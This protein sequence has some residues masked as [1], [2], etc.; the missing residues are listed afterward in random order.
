MATVITE[1]CINC[2][3]C[4]PECPN[5]AIYQGGVEY[6]W[7]GKKNP[8]IADE[9]FYIVPEKCTECVGFFDH[10]ACAA[11][12]PV[13]C[14][15][16][17]PARPE[18]EAALLQRAR[19]LHPDKEFAD[20]APSRFR[21]GSGDGAAAKAPAAPAAQLQAAAAPAAAVAATAVAA[22]PAP[23]AGGRVEKAIVRPT[24][25]L[26]AG[27]PNRELTGEL[28]GSFEDALAKVRRPKH[29]GGSLA[30]GLGLLAA[31]PILGALDH[32]TKLGIEQ[33]YGDP[34]FFSS[35]LS[36]AINVI[37]NFFLYPILLFVA[38]VLGG[39]QMFTEA[40]KTPIVM[41]VLIASIE[42]AV[43]LRDGVFHAKP[44]SEIRYGASI[45]GLPLGLVLR[46]I[47]SRF[48]KARRSGWVP[49]EGFYAR[50]FE[51]KRE[52]EKR[53]GEV[54]TVDEF[55]HGYYVRMEL[56][57]EIPPSA[58]RDELGIGKEMP[59][60][61]LRVAL[62]DGSLSIRG[63]VVDPD[64]RAICGVSPAFPA[65]FKTAIPLDAAIAGFRRRY[66]D[67]L[68]EVVVLKQGA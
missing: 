19:E 35:Q 12:C 10:E 23:A 5:T 31:S 26:K 1:E 13:D 58:A 20:D 6:D 9:I 50:E 32:K 11:V 47:V 44:A 25:K 33:A 15:V 16:P 65:D 28:E 3:A 4:E 53:Y 43:R 38:G 30:V 37:H 61:D 41:G 55:D 57:R 39:M 29:G 7:L 40:D 42:T 36:T 62:D 24:K 8:A 22:R 17:D 52:R 34:R 63:A 56:P 59:D 54:Y 45:Y 18:T 2:G 14:C 67:K 46:P 27:D 60:Y 49:V 21:K 66:A 68:L 51:P 64:L 48:V